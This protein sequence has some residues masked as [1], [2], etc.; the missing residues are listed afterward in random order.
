MRKA[1]PIINKIPS[2]T[3]SNN[4]SY[5]YTYIFFKK[6]P[7]GPIEP[8]GR[9]KYT[10]GTNINININM[11]YKIDRRSFLG[12]DMCLKRLLEG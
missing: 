4:I 10:S 1:F 11:N 5:T 9:E 8:R 3:I 6:V 7:Q 12:M 2:D